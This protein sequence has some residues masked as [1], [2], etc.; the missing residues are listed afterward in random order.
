MAAQPPRRFTIPQAK[1]ALEV[2]GPGN[3]SDRRGLRP[4]REPSLRQRVLA[5]WGTVQEIIARFPK[6]ARIIRAHR[7]D[8]LLAAIS[9]W[10][11]STCI[12][13]A[14]WRST[15]RWQ[16]AEFRRLHTVPRATLPSRPRSPS[17]AHAR[18]KEATQ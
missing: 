5:L 3:G 12:E 16:L 6:T 1:L 7:L 8:E 17:H 2:P 14:Y 10:R 15:A 9:E 11:R 4:E 13:R 18:H